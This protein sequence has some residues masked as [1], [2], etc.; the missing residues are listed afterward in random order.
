MAKNDKRLRLSRVLMCRMLAIRARETRTIPA[1]LE[2][3]RT[4]AAHGAT[5]P[6]SLRSHRDGWGIV[7][8]VGGELRHL[9]RAPSDGSTDPAFARA[10]AAASKVDPG[11]FL[12]AHL[13]NASV[14]KD[15]EA[16][17]HPFVRE[18]WAFCHNGTIRALSGPPRMPP[19]GNTDS[20]RYFLHLLAAH[21][22]TGSMEAAIREVVPRLAE[23]HRYSSLTFLLTNGTELYASRLV[24]PEPG[25]CGTLTCA[26]EHYALARAHYQDSQLVVQ[27]PGFLPG[28]TA[29][30]PL[31]N[32]SLWIQ[33]GK[34]AGR[35]VPLVED[36]APLP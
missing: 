21:N 17:T 35:V 1:V 8:Q 4:L 11:T 27:E 32:G 34:G 16:N 10:A 19:E 20:E 3:F 9:G 25:A 5:G 29:W 24:G 18:G 36:P 6:A 12:I 33:D 23:A 31:P 7:G 28:L 15:T 14:G 2:R 22:R 13:R 26:L 30:D